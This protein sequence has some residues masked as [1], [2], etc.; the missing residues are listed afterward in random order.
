MVIDNDKEQQKFDI[1]IERAEKAGAR[2]LCSQDLASY[3]IDQL[4][5]AL[6]ALREL[7]RYRLADGTDCWC[8]GTA[9]HSLGCQKA[10]KLLESLKPEN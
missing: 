9:H 6:D 8:T 2:I 7:C 5:A 1:F 10:R 3:V 4:T